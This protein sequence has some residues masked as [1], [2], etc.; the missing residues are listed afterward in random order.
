L[1]SLSP[2]SPEVSSLS[3]SHLDL[4]GLLSLGMAMVLS[5]FFFKLAVAPFH[6]WAPDVYEGSPT[7]S[8][9]Y[10]AVVPKMGVM[11]VRIRLIYGP[12]VDLF[13]VAQPMRLRGSMR[14]RTV[15]ALSARVQRRLKRFRAY[16]AIGHVGYILLGLS[17]GSLEGVQGS[18]IYRILYVIMSLNVWLSVMSLSRI[19]SNPSPLVASVSP[20]SAS[21]SHSPHEGS[22]VSPRV[23]S[24][25]YRTDL[26]GLGRTNPFLAATLSLSVRS[27]AGIPPLAGFM[28]KM[29]VFF[30]AVSQS[31]ILFSLFAVLTSCVGAFYY[32]R[33]IKIMYF[34]SAPTSSELVV[35]SPVD[36]MTSRVRGITLGRMILALMIPGPLRLLTHRMALALCR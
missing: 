6:A 36:P 10:F 27:M 32:R 18:L 15:A 2:S 19:H 28:A 13:R 29:W 5:A 7:P 25:K 26:G 9:L 1:R 11:R 16:S 34:E 8:T 14:S 24:A 22:V 33:W 17:S 20:L 23:L 4:L 12:F 30:S 35:L 31:L 21:P 3:G